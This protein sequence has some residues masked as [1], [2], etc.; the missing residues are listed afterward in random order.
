M[1]E[2]K[3]FQWPAQDERDASPQLEQV[4]LY[5]EA[6]EARLEALESAPKA[7]PEQDPDEHG[8]ADFSQACRAKMARKRE[9]GRGG[10]HDPRECPPGS[11]QQMLIA[12][13]AKGDPIDVAN[14][15]MMIWNRGESVRAPQEL[16][17]VHE[18]ARAMSDLIHNMVV[19]QQSAWIEWQRGHGAEAAM[20]WIHNALAGPGALPPRGCP[21][22]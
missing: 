2:L 14:F 11:L 12:H 8:W 4:C 18:N 16:E 7:P 21:L 17:R 10:W 15:A 19:G 22:Q 5:A 1:S 3:A 13:L 9:Q 6:L 20:T